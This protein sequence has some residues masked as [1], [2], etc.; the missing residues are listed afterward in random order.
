[1][2]VLDI[3]LLLLLLVLLLD[4]LAPPFSKVLKILVA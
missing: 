2:D 3:A 1:M 4:V